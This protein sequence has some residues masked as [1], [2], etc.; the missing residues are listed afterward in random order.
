MYFL[1]SQHVSALIIGHHQVILQN[2]KIEVLFIQR[3]RWVEWYTRMY[4]QNAA[5]HIR[6]AKYVKIE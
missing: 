5:V 1:V 6:S 2:I 3:I 4:R